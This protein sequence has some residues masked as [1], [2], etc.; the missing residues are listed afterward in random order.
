[1]TKDN[2]YFDLPKELIAQSPTEKRGESRLLVYHREKGE[3]TDS[4]VSQ[5]PF[6]LPHDSLLVFNNSR[7]RKARIYGE[8]EGGGRVE[9]LFLK[10]INS[11]SWEVVVSKQKKQV[12]G[13]RFRF[14]QG[15]EGTITQLLPRTRILELNCVLQESYFEHHG[16]IP[17]PPYIKRETEEFDS[18][19]YQTVYADALKT[20][21]AAAPTAGLHFTPELL[22][23]LEE[24][25]ISTA[26][27]TLHVGLG[28]FLPVT[29][30]RIQDH[31][32]HTEAYEVSE[33]TASAVNQAKKE[34]RPIVAVGTTSVRTLES[35]W[36]GG[37]IQSGW[38]QTDIFIYPGYQFQVVDK[39][40]TNFHTPDSSLILLV[41]A[42][43]GMQEI[44]RCYRHAVE[45]RYRF[46]SY[47]DATLFL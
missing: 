18:D 2:F 36:K 38:G 42:F 23:S 26:F 9:F 8:S 25:G 22:S 43:A 45:E 33:E 47:G 11:Q 34:G 10:P 24:K 31:K 5:L 15:V 21:S 41:S 4:F 19:R 29:A 7:V 1:M 32:M 27:V 13:K 30:E 20:G 44:Q 16:L 39:L 3:M 40:F 28:T 46:F 35:A 12:V 6:Y 14:P 17:L 37:E